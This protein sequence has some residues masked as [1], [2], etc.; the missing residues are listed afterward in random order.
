[1]SFPD[2]EIRAVASS[3]YTPELVA[4]RLA[5]MKA[6]LAADPADAEAKREVEFLENL[7]SKDVQ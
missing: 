5:E 2:V 3:S 6:K 7:R 4:K 1:M